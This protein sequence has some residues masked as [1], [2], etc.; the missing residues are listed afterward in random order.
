[1]D[2][3]PSTCECCII[4]FH[5]ADRTFTSVEMTGLNQSAAARTHDGAT[6]REVWPSPGHAAAPP[7]AVRCARRGSRSRA[8]CCDLLRART[9][10]SFHA[11]TQPLHA[12]LYTRTL[13]ADSTRVPCAQCS[14]MGGSR[15]GAQRCHRRVVICSVKAARVGEPTDAPVGRDSRPTKRQ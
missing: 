7:R 15:S 12:K 9:L 3:F 2:T 4:T 6:R 8:R 1:M 14:E 11:R 10:W 5:G 13:R